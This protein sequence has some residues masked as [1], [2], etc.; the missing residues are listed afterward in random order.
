ML[1]KKDYSNQ[2]KTVL[3]KEIKKLEKKKKYGIV[4]EDKTEALSIDERIYNEYK[5]FC[6]ESG[7]IL[8]KQVKFFIKKGI[9]KNNKVIKNDIFF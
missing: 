4:W 5:K 1:N 2:I 9:D 3:I 6:K 7:I 8:F